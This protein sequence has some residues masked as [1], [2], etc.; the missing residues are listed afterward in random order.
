MTFV[1]DRP[2]PLPD[3]P[4]ITLLVVTPAEDSADREILK[5]AAP[6]D[7]VITHDIPLAYELTKR[8]IVAIDD[9]GSVLNQDNIGDR[10]AIRNLLSGLRENGVQAEKT[11]PAT[12]K[13]VT[14]FANAFDR[15]LTRLLKGAGELSD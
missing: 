11:K 7:L 3:S 15:E 6:G 10:L 4:H 8:D 13:D 5:S 1:A 12:G 14:A 9:R 2:I